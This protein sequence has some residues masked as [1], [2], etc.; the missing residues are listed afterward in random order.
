MYLFNNTDSAQVG[1]DLVYTSINSDQ[2]YSGS[3]TLTGSNSVQDNY[4]LRFHYF[5]EYDYGASFDNITVTEQKTA[6]Y[7]WSANAPNGAA[8]WSTTN[9]EDITVTNSA[10]I[11]HVGSYALTVSDGTCA[12]TMRFE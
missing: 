11:D 12:V 6:V 4:T 5:G 3:I 10:T 1:S 9:T 8:G 2:T 7:S